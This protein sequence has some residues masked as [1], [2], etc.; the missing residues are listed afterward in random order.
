MTPNS[1]R[2]SKLK[3]IVFILVLIL[4]EICI[5]SNGLD[6]P[7]P[8]GLEENFNRL[9]TLDLRDMDVVDVFK[10]LSLK[11]DFSI[12]VS[13]NVTGRV[14]LVLKQVR[15]IDALDILVLSN[16]LGYRIRQNIVYVM[17]EEEYFQVYGEFFRD[18]RS[19]M[20]VYLSYVKP[21]YALET[22]KNIKSEIGKIVIDESTGTVVM[23]DTKEK[24]KKMSEV[25]KEI[26]HKLETKIFNLNYADAEVLKEKLREKLDVKSVGT[27]EAD[28]RSNQLIVTA[29]P[30]RFPEV[31]TIIK[32][33]DKKTKE[34]LIRVKILKIILNPKFDMGI[35]WA[36]TFDTTNKLL[37][38]SLTFAGGFPIATTVSQLGTLGQIAFGDIPPD[39]IE[40]D[41]KALKQVSDTKTLANPSILV[42]DGDEA[43]IHIGDKLAYVTTTTT[44]TGAD[45]TTNEEVH[46]VDVGILL[47]VKP[48]IS[49]NGYIKMTI[50]PEISSQT[51]TLTTPQQAEIPLI[52]TTLIESTVMVKDGTTIIIGGL[53]K[54]EGTY[55]KKG[56]PFI[57]DIPVI[58]KIFQNQSD[59][60]TKT[61]IA[62]FLTPIIVEG[63]VNVTGY[64]PSIAP[65]K[66]Y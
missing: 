60:T 13:K 64:T 52:N 37:T 6:Q 10:F 43:K 15:I 29:L 46:F 61:E 3:P 24:L 27:I 36:G 65:T 55:T 7:L 12:V 4:L 30:D 21:S 40:M 1:G 18:E 14:T 59:D 31:E 54:D 38:S 39:N 49:D 11:G 45:Q 63:D 23:I 33:L 9:I 48:T 47:S 44:G 32:A 19:V 2:Q 41:I 57:M 34:V 25:L 20:T 26:D 17:P 42:T 62:I 8:Q 66:S 51:D 53:H 28:K 16:G 5:P 22:L 58:G 56:L 50:K 35:N